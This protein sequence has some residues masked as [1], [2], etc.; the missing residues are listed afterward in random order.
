MIEWIISPAEFYPSISAEMLAFLRIG[1]GVTLLATL[2]ITLPNRRF[3]LSERW[4]G[5]AESARDVDWI[6]NPVAYP[7]VQ[8]IWMACAVL[9]T[10]GLWSVW[11][12]IINVLICRYFFVYMRWKGV[13][14]GMGAPGYMTY[15]MGLVIALLE[16]TTNYAQEATKLALL[17]VQIDFAFIMLSAGFYKLTAGYAHG[18]GME[19]GAA[20][21][22]WGFWPN[23]YTKRP[24]G[25]WLIQSFN[26][27]AWITEIAAGVLM[28]IAPLR[29][30]GGALIL[31]SFAFLT[32]QIRLGWLAHLVMICCAV[33]FHPGSILDEL[34]IS[35]IPD[36]L[37]G[38][39][40]PE[41]AMPSAL[42]VVLQAVLW[43]YIVLLPF[44]HLG[45][46]YNFYLKKSLPPPGQL[47]LER[48]TNFF[49]H[50]IW[51][52]FSQ[53][54][55]NFYPMIYHQSSDGGPRTLISRYGWAGGGFL[56]RYNHVCESIVLSSLFTTLKYYPSN[57]DRFR[58]R[59]LRY[60]RTLPRPEEHLIIFEYYSLQRKADGSGVAHILASEF[61]VDVERGTVEERK[62][63]ET[64]SPGAAIA[65]SPVHEGV[66]PGSYVPLTG[67]T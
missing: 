41:I 2:M 66:R 35:V 58:D 13:A 52:V 14:R 38:T 37:V 24:P 31:L 28:L 49:G 46:S 16:F 63:D 21:P 3:F 44:S 36:S 12:A 54:I 5:Y 9:I 1:Y 39:A 33:Y 6:Q 30:V 26:Q 18:N 19:L 42:I 7:V 62:I 32:T 11:A 48:Y 56:N 40:N 23:F 20:N 15:W 45:L 29:F 25:H 4:G 27:M 57:T 22:E 55:V 50:I 67:K 17:A 10:L 34:V 65:I 59:M 47:I 64:F 53:D 61:I 60:C 51:R 43:A 8:V